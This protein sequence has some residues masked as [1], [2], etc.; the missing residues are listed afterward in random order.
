[1]LTRYLETN[2]VEYLHRY[3]TCSLHMIER[4]W[5]RTDALDWLWRHKSRERALYTN[6]KGALIDDYW[7]V[8]FWLDTISKAYFNRHVLENKYIYSE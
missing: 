2:C 5:R 7:R 4:V 1:M 3:V 8:S 6:V